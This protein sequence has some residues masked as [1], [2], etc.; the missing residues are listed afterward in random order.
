MLVTRWI[1]IAALFDRGIPA[2]YYAARLYHA[3]RKA[4]FTAGTIP[5]RRLPPPI[6]Y[7]Y[8]SARHLK[9][10]VTWQGPHNGRN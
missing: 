3:C 5:L 8:R 1:I 4:L 7:V 9:E 10:V 6:D 2:W